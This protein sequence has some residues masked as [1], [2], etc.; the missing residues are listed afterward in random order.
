MPGTIIPTAA[1]STTRQAFPPHPSAPTITRMNTKLCLIPLTLGILSAQSTLPKEWIDPDT[2]HRV[3]RLSEEDGT[4]SLYF[5][6]NAYS[7]D[8]KKLVVTNSH[9]IATI[10]LNT[11][12]IDQVVEG[13]VNILVTGHKTGQI[14]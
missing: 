11:R 5:H 4:A 2:G 14:Y 9:G 1:I 13:K 7:A 3:V 10:D 12:K 8:G 6:Q